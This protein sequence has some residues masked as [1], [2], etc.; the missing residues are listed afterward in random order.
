[1]SCFQLVKGY[2][3]PG[4]WFALVGFQWVR[5]SPQTPTCK[6]LWFVLICI[7]KFSFRVDFSLLS[8]AFFLL[9][10]YC[11]PKIWSTI[12]RRSSKLLRFQSI[13]WYMIQ[14][15][16]WSCKGSEFQYS[17]LQMAAYY[18][19]LAYLFDLAAKHHVVFILFMPLWG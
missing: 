8:S 16:L 14:G 15:N 4:C 5:L 2:G 10:G 6:N 19:I 11:S 18:R 12:N 3:L 17:C 7:I 1:M 13:F 9:V